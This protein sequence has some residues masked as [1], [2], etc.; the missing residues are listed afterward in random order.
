MPDS[1]V[2]TALRRIPGLRRIPAAKLFA[3]GEVVLLAR[4]HVAR[5]EPS[6]RRR[7]LEL[8]RHTHGRPRNLSEA[9]R[10]ELGALIA[11]ADP[12]L[13]VGLLAERFSPVPLPKRVVRGPKKR[14]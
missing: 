10:A 4:Q 13:F 3:L 8:M 7:F 2:H 5:L 9:E 12:R 11:K 6:E 1:I 14:R